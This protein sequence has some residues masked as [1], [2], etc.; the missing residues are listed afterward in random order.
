MEQGEIDL[1]SIY[2]DGTKIE[3]NANRYTFVWKKSILKYQERLLENICKHLNISRD[4]SSEEMKNLVLMEFNN[5]RNI[6]KSKNIVFVCG[7]GKRKT[8]EQRKYELYEEWIDKLKKYE[9][10]L[11]IMGERNSYSKIDKNATFIRL[12]DDHMKNGQL[13]PAY[14][15]QCAANG[16][17][18]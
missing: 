8:E 14:N 5:I 9:N 10:H 16:D 17:T 18:L 13:K 1:K 15:I 12:K 4:L 3:A 2:I 6:C 11:N 7:Q